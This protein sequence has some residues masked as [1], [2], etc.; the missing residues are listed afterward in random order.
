LVTKNSS[1]EKKVADLENNCDDF[2]K[3]SSDLQSRMKE[4]LIDA[5]KERKLAYIA[6]EE[7]EK[8]SS[9][10][11]STK[12]ERNRWKQKADSLAKEMA[13]ICRGGNIGDVENL[14]NDHHDL[15]KE[16][17]LLRSQKKKAEE[18]LETSLAT[19]ATYVQAQESLRVD[20][21]SIR[22]AQK[23]KELERLVS[24]MTEYISAKE[25]QLESIQA[26]NRTLTDELHLAH[27]NNLQPNDV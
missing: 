14:I 1:L 16:V 11:Q 3:E 20:G 22:L 12:N 8:I 13:K 10:M 24:H 17:T 15:T 18:E 9:Q 21:S 25:T 5:D 2:R 26:V 19:H 27:Q 6:R 4:A 23:C 7:A